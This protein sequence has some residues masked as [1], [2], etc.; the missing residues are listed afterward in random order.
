MNTNDALTTF[1]YSRIKRV[2]FDLSCCA[3]CSIY[4]F[5]DAAF[6]M[7]LGDLFNCDPVTTQSVIESKQAGRA[8]RFGPEEEED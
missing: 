1:G 7:Y 4:S 3:I 5:Q 8:I 2:S 6:I